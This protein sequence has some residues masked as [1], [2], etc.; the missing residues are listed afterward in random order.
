MKWSWKIGR[1]RGIDILMHWTFLLLIGWVAAGSLLAGHGPL[2]AAEG[3]VLILAVFACV[4]LHEL[5]H[6]LTARYYG[7]PT[8]NI[9]L[10]PIGG[11]AQFERMPREPSQELWITLAGP[12]VNVVIAAVI[13][14]VGAALGGLAWLGPGQGPRGFVPNLLFQLFWVNVV[15]VIFNLLPA[16]PMDG[17][18][19]LRSFLARHL[20]Y[21]QAT[22]MAAGVGKAMAVLFGIAGLF[23]NPWLMLIAVFVYF[24]AEAEA[25]AVQESDAMAGVT[26][27]EAMMTRFTQLA[28]DDS[29]QKAAEELL[30]GAQQDFP[31]LEGTEVRGLLRRQDLVDGLRERGSEHLVREVMTSVPCVLD[32][33]LPL[34]ETLPLMRDSGCNTLPVLRDNNLVGLITLENVGELLLLRSAQHAE[35]SKADAENHEKF[36]AA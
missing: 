32:D 34:S 1:V 17:G 3:V 23:W 16:F 24:G 4:V 5:G 6:A 10:L 35:A 2:A 7:I 9:T 28:P 12:A 30:A 33:S 19:I 14:L 36:R 11:V 18:R 29:L 13:V 31:V 20:N 21:V 26:V 22:E 25:R 15:L 8:V 27:R